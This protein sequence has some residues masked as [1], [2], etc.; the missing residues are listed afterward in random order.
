MTAQIGTKED[1]YDILIIGA[2]PH[3]LTLVVRL[4]TPH[5]ASLYTDKEQERFVRS[6]KLKSAIRK[7]RICVVDEHGAWMTRWR[8]LFDEYGIDWMRSLV[9]VHPD[10]S[11]KGSLRD[12]AMA[13][14][15]L[16]EIK[17]IDDFVEK[18]K[19]R[20]SGFNH[21]QHTSFQIPSSSLFIDFCAHLVEQLDL[22]N[23][24]RQARVTRITP[25][26]SGEFELILTNRG[27]SVIPL[28]AKRVVCAI[29][30]V[31]IPNVPRWVQ[32]C[33]ACG[34]R[35]YPR[36]ALM[37]SSEL[38]TGGYLRQCRPTQKG[39]RV[40][41]VG[42]GLTAGHLVKRGA[43]QFDEVI[44]VTRQHLRVKQFDV[45]LQWVDRHS[46][47]Y[48]CRFW[49]ES[50]PKGRLK[51]IQ[52]ARQGGSINGW[53]KEDLSAMQSSGTLRIRERVQILTATWID[54]STEL[55]QHWHVELD[56]GSMEC[57]NRIWMA[58]GSKMDAEHDKLLSQ[59]HRAIPVGCT[60]GLPM[61]TTDLKWHPQHAIYVMGGYAALQ[62]GPNALNLAGAKIAADRIVESIRDEEEESSEC[63]VCVG[64]EECQN[65]YDAIALE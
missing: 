42:G 26:P 41:I 17:E 64:L 9:D 52:T 62:V 14:N 2:G 21:A 16:D 58:T 48:L 32:E 44:V 5:P 20:A 46:A 53:M 15:R 13:N 4:L 25:V 24:V 49:Q 19:H 55:G 45:S 10:A 47:S 54:N 59:L 56:D 12:F 40:M 30:N 3:A 35:R 36:D 27:G 37:H 65:R 38:A 57:V 63:Q 23:V 1:P 33:Q 22:K 11:D 6:S 39:R 50:D 43:C 34:R 29:G 60:E 8:M 51:M 7:E 18:N 31:G 61:L 28:Y